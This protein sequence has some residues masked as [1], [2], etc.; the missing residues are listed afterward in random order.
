MVTEVVTSV[1]DVHLAEVVG[2]A[3]A[4]PIGVVEELDLDAS[5]FVVL[6]GVHCGHLE[7]RGA[8]ARALSAVQIDSAS[9]KPG[10]H[11]MRAERKRWQKWWEPLHHQF[12]CSQD[13]YS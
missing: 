4:H 13:W 7:N 3:G 8:R 9:S 5:M 6:D 12:G 11:W 1:G 2:I 10:R